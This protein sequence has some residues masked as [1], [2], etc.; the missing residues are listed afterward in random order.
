VSRSSPP[1]DRGKRRN[2]HDHT[3]ARH[4]TGGDDGPTT[5]DGPKV[6]DL[7][8]GGE[9][10]GVV[11][12][13]AIDGA[14]VTVPA[15][16][17]DTVSSE[18]DLE[19][20]DFGLGDD[21]DATEDP[22]IYRGDRPQRPSSSRRLSP[23]LMKVF[24]RKRE[25]IGLSI[26]Q[27]AKLTGI[28]EEE[29]MRFEGTNGGHRLVYDHVVLLAR[30]LGIRAAELPGLRATRD[31]KDAVGGA[32]ASLHTA[33]LAGPLLTFEGKSG[34]RYGGDLERVGTTPY[35]AVRIGDS[36]IGEA[37]PKGAL[38][39][40]L[41]DAAPQ[42]GDVVMVRNKRA[43][44]LGIRRAAPQGFAPLAAWQPPYSLNGEWAAMSRLQMVLP[45]F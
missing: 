33:L 23:T 34:E 5:I 26:E 9:A 43:R 15:D 11:E 28:D 27:V 13:T 22:T 8:P 44:Q 12:P 35:F 1:H 42:Q 2:Q 20:D 17:H 3:T 21:W 10:S 18:L 38:L 16:P 39:C 14:H 24:Q 19:N 25:Q 30:V 6:R 36:S 32:L 31:A 4:N 41:M 7:L 29:L 40:F 37:W 45:R